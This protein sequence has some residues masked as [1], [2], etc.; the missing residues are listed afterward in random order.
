MA[1]SDRILRPR[2]GETSG[3]RGSALIDPA[4]PPSGGG[5]SS[6]REPSQELTTFTDLVRMECNFFADDHDLVG[7]TELLQLHG[8]RLPVGG[9]GKP[10]FAKALHSSPG[11]KSTSS[12]PGTG[13]TFPTASRLN[14]P[15][16]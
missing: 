9:G 5:R 2:P 12:C 16:C 13:K 6:R 3:R 14:S 4:R 7:A 10:V 8:I 1:E 15:A 11:W